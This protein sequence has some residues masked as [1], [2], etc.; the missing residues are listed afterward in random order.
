MSPQAVNQV[1]SLF[2]I[3]Q[4]KNAPS[5]L[6]ERIRSYSPGN[7]PF[8]RAVA[9]LT[10]AS[11]LPDLPI[12]AEQRVKLRHILHWRRGE[13]IATVGPKGQE[14]VLR[15]IFDVDGIRE[16]ERF[17]Q[18]PQCKERHKD[19][20]R[21]AYVLLGTKPDELALDKKHGEFSRRLAYCR[22]GLLRLA[23]DADDVYYDN[24]YEIQVPFLPRIWNT[25][26]APD[27]IDCNDLYHKEMYKV[28]ST[29][30]Y[31]SLNS[32]PG[33]TFVYRGYRLVAIH[34]HRG[35]DVEMNVPK[36]LS[37][38]SSRTQEACFFLPVTKEDAIL[39]IGVGTAQDAFF[40]VVRF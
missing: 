31:I 24:N 35:D 19:N 16:I 33:L 18:K 8:W 10:V 34:P 9:A 20:P 37:S 11:S 23:F 4:L 12:F 15:L 32:V 2:G 22:N 7:T 17:C 38:S 1:A 5:E 36:V 14:D 6:V 25:L 30:Y 26:T 40:V 27:L 28:F 21:F 3:P 29:G 39:G 13:R